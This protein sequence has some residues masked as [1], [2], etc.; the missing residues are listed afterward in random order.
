[1][2]KNSV[3]LVLVV[4][5]LAA[6]AGAQST[7]YST[8]VF[9]ATFNSSVSVKQSGTTGGTSTNVFYLSNSASVPQV[10]GVRT[11]NPPGIDVNQASLNVYAADALKGGKIQDDRKDALIQGHISTYI[12]A[13]Y[14]DEANILTRRRSLTIILNARTVILIMQEAGASSDD[15]GARDWDTLIKS[16][17]ISEKTCWLPEGCS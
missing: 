15:G 9:S 8:N 17:V 10:V 2:K 11:I 1:M 6:F 13:H 7:P 12:N 3:V 14:T 16:L 5:F 4:L